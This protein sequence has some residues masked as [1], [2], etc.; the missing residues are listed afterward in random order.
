[1]REIF[2][3]D[4][5]ELV[6]RYGGYVEVEE[7][8]FLAAFSFIYGYDDIV[9]GY[10]YETFKENLRLFELCETR[11]DYTEQEVEDVL[12][13]FLR[14]IDK[15]IIKRPKEEVKGKVVYGKAKI[16]VRKK[17]RSYGEILTYDS[18]LKRY[19]SNILKGYP[20]AM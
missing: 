2:D 15:S 12:L 9:Y 5:L 16:K 1:M 20:T 3:R 19:F 14:L 4:A 17:D 13:E 10:F 7:F 6:K 8:E 18:F 11:Q